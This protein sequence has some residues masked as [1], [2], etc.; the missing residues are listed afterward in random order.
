MRAAGLRR[1][2]WL[3]TGILWLSGLIWL[4][5]LTQYRWLGAAQMI[6]AILLFLRLSFRQRIE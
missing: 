3:A 5:L 1:D 2:L 4:A 6:A